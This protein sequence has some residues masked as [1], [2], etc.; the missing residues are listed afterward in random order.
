MDVEPGLPFLRI[1]ELSKRVGVSEHLLRAWELRYGLTNPARSPGGYRLYT[2]ADEYRLR[3]MLTYLAEGLAA[4]QAA[5]AAIEE[6]DRGMGSENGAFPK[7]VELKEAHSALR[8]R[9]DR[10]DEPGAQVIMDRL[11]TDF[12]VES[13]LRDLFVPYLQEMG[14]RWERGTFSVGQEHFASNVIRGRLLELTRGWGHGG[15]DVALLACPPGEEHEFALLMSG[16]V[17]HRSGW[18]IRYLGAN[19]PMPDLL[20]VAEEIRPAL[21]LLASPIADHFAD[22][23][24]ELSK[25]AK[26]APLVLSGEGATQVVVDRC[27]ARRF[28]GDPV[29]AAQKLTQAM[30]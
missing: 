5:R 15:G 28:P 1:G 8:E 25:L 9:L 16:I 18:S 6:D 17:L 14:D 10:L 19:T 27:G 11:F 3:R 4:A 21:I 12:T 13:L 22:V 29:T 26:L 2:S 7:I 24:T 30:K 20:Q 23:I